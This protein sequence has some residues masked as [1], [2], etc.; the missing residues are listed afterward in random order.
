MNKCWKFDGLLVQ[1]GWL[2][3][4]RVLTD[5]R[6]RLV[7]INPQ[8]CD[9]VVETVRGYA[10]PGF[11]NAHSH[12]FQYAM[13]GL[14]EHLRDDEDDFWSWRQAMYALALSISPGD[15]EHIATMLYAEMLRQG[16]TAV[17]EF[18]YLHHDRD[19]RPFEQPAAMGEALVAAA[20]TTGIHLTLI[21][22]FYR[23]GDFDTLPLPQQ[24]RFLSRDVDAYF[25]LL[26]A[27]GRAISRYERCRLGVGIHSLRAA[28]PEDIR[29]VFESADKDAPF[30]MHIAEQQKEVDSCLV[31]LKARPVQ[32]LLDNAPIDGRC[33]LVHATHL[34]G[35]EVEGI[36]AS[37]ASVVLCPS[38]EGNLGDGF[39]PLR[40][41]MQAGGFWSIG[42]DSN[43]G[44]SPM[45]ELRWLDYGLRLG[46][47]KRN[48]LCHKRGEDSGT[49]AFHQSLMGGRR[50][51]G[52]PETTYFRE[53]DP[54][55]ALV[56]QRD[57]PLLGSTSPNRRLATLIYATDG[58]ALLGTITSG[59]WVV[60]DQAH[61]RAESITR[62]FS[63]TMKTLANRL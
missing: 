49:I 59:R 22:I 42:T 38:T 19:G 48:S 26:S 47:Q 37:G 17:V 62:A 8:I 46:L 41:L 39:F 44:L 31:Y 25:Q 32:W 15:L 9:A 43:V 5:E 16:F 29:A 34:T 21:P 60:R 23:T 6:G 11:Q 52:Q 27:T 30:H 57:H 24:R 10:I 61:L 28:T 50:A 51:M 3:N 45:E 58:T 20:R 36:A 12:A 1:D 56:L 7:A 14:A 63:K 53:G 55:D 54:F 13:A 4:A 33:H 40:D 18:H 35:G 2:E